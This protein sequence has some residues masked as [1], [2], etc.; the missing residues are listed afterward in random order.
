M[1]GLMIAAEKG[2]AEV[3]CELIAAHAKL[4]ERDKFGYTALMIAVLNNN[5]KIVDELIKGGAKLD[6]E[7]EQNKTA[8]MLA[9][10]VHNQDIITLLE[11][12]INEHNLAGVRQ[13]VF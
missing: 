11:N 8:F 7:N 12:A 5:I 4:E 2:S 9:A 6:T 1:T 13:G 3:A 10:E